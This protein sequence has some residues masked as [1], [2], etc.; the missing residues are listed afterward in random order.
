MMSFVII[1]LTDI[2]IIIIIAIKLWRMRRLD[3]AAHIG[4]E[5]TYRQETRSVS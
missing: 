2:T 4:Q 1:T 3:Y 5:N